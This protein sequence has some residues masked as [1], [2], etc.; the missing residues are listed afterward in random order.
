MESF[1]IFGI[2]TTETKHVQSA[3]NRNKI[4]FG[5]FAL[6]RENYRKSQVTEYSDDGCKRKQNTSGGSRKG[7]EVRITINVLNWSD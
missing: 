1:E 4:N 2:R 6:F 7:S 5:G 3:K